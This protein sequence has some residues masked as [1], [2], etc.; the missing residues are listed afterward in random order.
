[1]SGFVGQMMTS[2]D[3]RRA[4]SERV[5]TAVMGFRKEGDHYIGPYST[6]ATITDRPAFDGKSFVINLRQLSDAET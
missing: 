6:I 4:E 3:E 5:L 2:N 1:L